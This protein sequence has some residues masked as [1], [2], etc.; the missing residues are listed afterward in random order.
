MLVFTLLL[1]IVGL[2]IGSFL[3]ACVYRVPRGIS[4]VKPRSSCS[5]CGVRLMWRDLVPMVGPFLNRWKCRKCNAKIP[6]KYTAIEMV[7][8]AILFLLAFGSE[9]DDGLPARMAFVLTLIPIIWIDWEFFIIPNKILAVGTIAIMIADLAF[10]QDSLLPRVGLAAAG[11]VLMMVIRTV[12]SVLLEKPAIGMG[13]VKL[14]GFIALQLGFAGLLCSLWLGAV[15]ALAYGGLFK[16]RASSQPL[17]LSTGGSVNIPGSAIPYGSFLSVASMAVL[18]T[19]ER[20]QTLVS[21][22][23]ISIS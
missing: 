13:D 9:W 16:A 23:L 22:W 1:V 21:A 2:A 15:G 20:L 4:I 11:V 6:V 17:A 5:A 7:T 8:A 14:G 18:S 12:G 10:A 19:L 3:G